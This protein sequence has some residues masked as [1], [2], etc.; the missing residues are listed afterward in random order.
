MPLKAGGLGLR[1]RTSPANNQSIIA[2]FFPCVDESPCQQ[3]ELRVETGLV[4]ESNGV[5]TTV[6]YEEKLFWRPMSSRW[7][8]VQ[9][10]IP[11]QLLCLS[12]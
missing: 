3:A 5:A 11:S 10:E 4:P 9:S 1:A 2:I 6:R 8:L 12:D 7:L